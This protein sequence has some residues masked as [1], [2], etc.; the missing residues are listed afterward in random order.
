MT[1]VVSGASEQS[2]VQAAYKGAAAVYQN[3]VIADY[4]RASV[5]HILAD[6]YPT[7]ASGDRVLDLGCGTGIGLLVLREL[8][9]QLGQSVG[10]D[11]SAQMLETAQAETVQ[12]A[13]AANPISWLQG[14]A[15]TLPFAEN[16]FDLLISHN[17]F[18]WFPDRGLALQEI[19]RVLKPTGRMALLFEGQ[20]ARKYSLN[21]RRRVLER[22]GLQ[23]PSGFG[24]SAAP[25]E[26]WNSLAGV[27]KLVEEAGLEIIDLWGRQS[28]YYLPVG[29]IVQQFRSTAAY[30]QAGLPEDKVTQILTE[31][32][33]ELT[34]MATQRGFREVLY[35]IN[36]IA[37]KKS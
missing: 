30:W 11:L 26:A 17:A 37:R 7:P 9:P 22:H 16:S 29:I 27:E 35:P 19:R 1:S 28:Y 13:N 23:A 6:L 32:E 8:Y 4:Q 15:Q 21:V 10:L 2:K 18:H 33:A 36:V 12:S 31:M 25:G 34:A 5:R 14:N 3:T 24:N 20:T